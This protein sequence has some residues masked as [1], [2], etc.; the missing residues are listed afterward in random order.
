MKSLIF[1]AADVRRVVEHSLSAKAQGG[2]TTGYDRLSGKALT[3]P[4]GAPAVLL[5][6]DKGIYLMSNGEP[7]DLLDEVQLFVSY[8]H[9]CHPLRDKNWQA[10][11]H[12]LVGGDDFALLLPWAHDLKAVID[13]GAQTVTLNIMDD[14]I[15]I[16]SA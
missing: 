16:A 8:A 13:A 6:R 9:G 11:A 12:E 1:D 10:A 2:K 14:G 3:E 5:V 7:R 15:E 4:V